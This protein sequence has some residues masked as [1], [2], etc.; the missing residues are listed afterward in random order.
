[1]LWA[2]LVLSLAGLALGPALVALGR[3]NRV[4]N[5]A[6]DG[7]TIGVVPLLVIVRLMPHTYDEIGVASILYAALGFTLVTFAHRG[8]QSAETKIGQALVLPTLALHALADGAAL[9]LSASSKD[10]AAGAL[11]AAAI[12]LHRLPEGLFVAATS[13][14]A[15]GWRRTIARLALLAGATIAGATAG[16][17]LLEVV[18]DAVFDGLVSF[19]LGAM[20]RLVVH[21]HEP[22]TGARDEHEHD[23]DVGHARRPSQET[24]RSRAASGA[25]FVVGIAI[26]LLVPAPRNVLA[27]AQPSEPSIAESLLPLFVSI[28]P[29][30]LL[31]LATA[32]ALHRLFPRAALR[33]GPL[34]ALVVALVRPLS[35]H[36]VAE[37]TRVSLLR[38]TP[39]FALVFALSVQA[40]GVD[41]ALLSARVLGVPMTLA[42]VF[43]AALVVVIASAIAARVAEQGASQ[44][45]FGAPVATSDDATGGDAT[46]DLDRGG[47]WLVLGL[48]LAAVIDAALDPRTLARAPAPLDVLAAV[49]FA[50]PVTFATPAAIPIAAVLVHK[51]LSAGAALAF[52]I[53]APTCNYGALVEVRAALGLRSSIALL[54]LIPA[55]AAMLGIAVDRRF[56]QLPPVHALYERPGAFGIACAVV[57]VA[58]LL[59]S[60]L[61]RGA[62]GWL[63]TASTNGAV[64]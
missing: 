39:L 41:A 31:G 49:L 61:R 46:R 58:L 22:F 8:G 33:G 35:A 50:I 60:M 2:L 44:A 20:L 21:E 10:R 12:V 34:R 55:L 52:L 4:A 9:A 62:R 64:E 17:S 57:L 47:A 18:P 5:S 7:F 29:A 37:T 28:A 13:V 25:A 15:I 59:V 51:G 3:T 26:A 16:H 43:G 23:H 30:V 48:V 40:I 11:L 56:P 27:R 6:I 53:V 14:P 38:A 36:H 32:I 54:V 45:S 1:M 24:P 19:G 63:A 42:R